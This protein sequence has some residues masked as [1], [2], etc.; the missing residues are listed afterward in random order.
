MDVE[1]PNPARMAKDVTIDIVLKDKSGEVIATIKDKLEC[2]DPGA[3]YHYGVTKKIRG[4]AVGSIAA[5]AKASSYL[6]LQTPLMKHIALSELRLARENAAMRFCGKMTSNYPSDLRSVILHYQFLDAS[7]KILGGGSEWFFEEFKVG[8]EKP[9]SIPCPVPIKG[10]TKIV[11]S[12][13]FNAQDLL[14]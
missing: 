5:T 8:E 13:D 11:Y 12:I 14:K 10:A 3:I 9:F 7:N 1:N 4:G 6:R 2:I